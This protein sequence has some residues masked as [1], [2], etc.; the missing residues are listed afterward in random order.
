MAFLL[1]R[2]NVYL[3]HVVFC[4][5]VGLSFLLALVSYSTIAD[6]LTVRWNLRYKMLIR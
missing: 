2:S 1:R 4:D 3:K 6:G 5:G